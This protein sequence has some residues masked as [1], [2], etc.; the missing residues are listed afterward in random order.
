[1]SHRPTPTIVD[2]IEIRTER[3]VSDAGRGRKGG[4]PPRPTPRFRIRVIRP[5]KLSLVKSI[6]ESDRTTTRFA[7]YVALSTAESDARRERMLRVCSTGQ[8]PARLAQ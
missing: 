5:Q 6:E 1:M 2:T 3:E 8:S 4:S 7:D